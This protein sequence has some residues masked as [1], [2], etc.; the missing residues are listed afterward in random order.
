MPAIEFM[1]R[2]IRARPGQ[3]TLLS[4]GPFTN[5]ALL[6]ALDPEIPSLLKS[7]V[8]MAGLYYLQHHPFD[9]K[10][11]WNCRVDPISTGMVYRDAPAGHLSFGLDV[12]MKCT[13]PPDQIRQRFSAGRPLDV[14][15]KLAEVWFSHAKSLTFHDPLAAAA[16]FRPDICT[17][18]DGEVKVTISDDEKVSALTA[19]TPAA[20]G[21][22]GRHR[23]A[24]SVRPDAFFQE[25]FSVFT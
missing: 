17:Y 16:I 9:W 8:S 20:P 15:L 18:E 25:Y 10:T 6:F 1:R 11:E 21:Q 24:K 2:T 4:V 7:L 22:P 14:V 12:T 13:M 19:F 23:V 3:I 5:V